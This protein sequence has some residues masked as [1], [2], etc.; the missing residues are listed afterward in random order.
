MEL[1]QKIEAARA[2]FAAEQRLGWSDCNDSS[3]A[4][5]YIK[6]NTLGNL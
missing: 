5:L 2:T 1:T 3:P 4:Y 6:N